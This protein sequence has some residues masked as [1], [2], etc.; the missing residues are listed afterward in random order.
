[1]ATQATI[2]NILALLFNGLSLALALGLLILVLWQ[3]PNSTANR[4][5]AL[6]LLSALI[7]ASG[8]M[9]SRAAAYVNAGP[10]LIQAGLRLLDFG[11][12]ASALMLYS[13]SAVIGGVRGRWFRAIA[14]GGLALI[15]SYQVLLLLAGTPRPYGILPDGGLDYRFDAPSLVLFLTFLLATVVIIWGNR[16]RVRAPGL[17]SGILL[18]ALALMMSLLSPRLRTLGTPEILG[19][20]A[21]V[22]MSYAIVRQQ[23]MIPL[24]G[25]A[26]QLEAVRDV[27]IAI[28]SRL[29]LPETLSA[30]TAQAVNL[31]EADG[32]AIYLKHGGVL[33][34][35]A[36][37]NL[38]EQYVGIEIPLGQAVVGTVALERRGRRVDNYH[39]EWHGAPDMPWADKAFGAVIAV[40]LLFAEEV[41][42]V[43]LVAQG[44]Q[45]RLFDRE[46]RYLLELLGPQAA[47]AITNSRLFEAE[48]HLSSDLAGAKNQLETVLTSTKNPVI[49]IDRDLRILF[50]NPA[51][52]A[53]LGQGDG[54]PAGRR[55]TDVAPRELL[56]PNL[57]DALRTLR[58]QRVFV[59]EL[60]AQG[61]TYLCHV[62]EINEP[63]TIGWV[64]V[65]NDV[66]Q[67][68]ELDRLKSQMIQMTSHDLKNPLQAA[69]S[70]LELLTEDGQGVFTDDMREDI[71]T[72]WTQLHRMYRIISGILNLERAQS[73]VPALEPCALDEILRRVAQDLGS[74]AHAKAL[75]LR[76]D[77]PPSLMVLGDAQQLAQAFANLI[78]N[79]IKFTP[80]G[81]GVTVQAAVKERCVEVSVSD[82]GI[83]IALEEQ[84]HV[85]D[86]FYRSKQPGAAH[87]SGSGLGLS[88]VQAIVRS[89][90][91]TIAL[92][93]APGQG[94][95]VRVC[96]PLL[97]ETESENSA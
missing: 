72:I 97:H 81:G 76:L 11:F 44:R 17:V 37:H 53:L 91:G 58:R 55:L 2:V 63:R 6:F 36:V 34:L 96:L 85:F 19:A 71:N 28:T 50:A 87:L 88:L 64:S 5:F 43:L 67:L 12:S 39:S 54:D 30:I 1:M 7:W 3:D 29:R 22:L 59:Y 8:S 80:A 18:F 14:L 41:V 20:L 86:R 93:S 31:L 46:D 45:G 27:G 83:G 69:M 4:F 82:T 56:P 24:L 40:P 77:V 57:R 94:T 26:K 35:A 73:G 89:H 48:R 92:D 62:G 51:A 60:S 10:D 70:Y 52:I 15:L 32:G 65:L 61:R 23:I 13:Y 42:G 79:G 90:H 78:D 84:A 95:T 47:V 74:Q 66:T 16:K 75:T 9:L 25:R 21:I 38:P 33:R 68:K 49:A